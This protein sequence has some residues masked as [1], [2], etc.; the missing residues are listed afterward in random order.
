MNRPRSIRNTSVLAFL[1]G[2]IREDAEDVLGASVEWCD[3]LSAFLTA[4][5]DGRW[6][7]ALLS[8]D[9]PSVDEHIAAR[10][11]Q[12]LA[13][14]A[15]FL[16]SSRTSVDQVMAAERTGAAAL[17]SQPPTEEQW[18]VEV[19]PIVDESGDVAVPPV[20]D[21]DDDLVVATSPALMDVFRV[22]ARVAS[23]EAT[24]LITGDSGTGKELVAR[25]L[26]TQGARA[27]RPFVA[28]NC[29]AIPDSLLEAELFG[30]EKGAF[31]G[32][33]ASSKGRFGRADGG[34]LFLDEIGDLSRSLQAKLLRVL[35]TGE[36]ERLGGGGPVKVDVRIVAATNQPLRDRADSGKFREDLLFRLAVVE[37]ELPPLRRRREDVLPLAL[38]FA[39]LFSDRYRRPV[40]ALSRQASERLRTYPWPGNVRELR[41]VIDRAVLLAKGGVVRSTDVRLGSEAPRTSPA[42]E[43]HGVGYSPTMSLRDVEAH[44]I[45][46]V[47]EHTAGH[48][49]EAAEILGIHRNT[50]T[51]KV[52]EYGIDLNEFGAD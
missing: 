41:N 34:T 26:H 42:D 16:T 22:V 9:D 52:R 37:V 18:R 51:L 47:L 40:R 11:A 23:T 1:P 50:M 24:V 45:R 20:A 6:R 43:A 14:E 25:A 38:H 46:G 33:V 3:G 29:A 35:E 28:V 39:A 10:V 36:V 4:V 17:L 15:L 21:S 32:A 31:T 2:T 19:R 7:V 44:H 48:M 5:R 12:S 8:L 30:Y 49:G 13:P 27:R